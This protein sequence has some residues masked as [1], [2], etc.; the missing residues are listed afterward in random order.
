M[1]IGRTVVRNV[2]WW[3][4]TPGVDSVHTLGLG[5][6][7]TGAG[8]SRIADVFGGVADLQ[9][10]SPVRVP[11]RAHVP[12]SQRPFCSLTVD[13]RPNSAV[14]VPVLVA[15][16]DFSWGLG[17]SILSRSPGWAFLLL[18]GGVAV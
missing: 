14:R 8:L 12:P 4:R 1:S 2:S 10:L 6:G 16:L 3:G 9:A 15:V 13:S 11:L 5:L 7:R 18:H 17:A